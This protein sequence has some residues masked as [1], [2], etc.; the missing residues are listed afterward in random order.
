MEAGK[1][2]LRRV[3]SQ[4][5]GT[6]KCEASSEGPNFN[7]DFAESNLTVAGKF[8]LWPLLFTSCHLTCAWQS[9]LR[10]ILKL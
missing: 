9:W 3:N 10:L 6:Y 4:A 2:L 8:I 1:V 7:T 5:E